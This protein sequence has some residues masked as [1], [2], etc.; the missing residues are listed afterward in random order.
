MRKVLALMA[1]FLAVA[2]LA[3]P[4]NPPPCQAPFVDMTQDVK[5][6]GSFTYTFDASYDYK[7][8][9]VGECP[10]FTG[11]ACCKDFYEEPWY[12]RS[13]FGYTLTPLAGTW[14]CTA[15]G[16]KM[17]TSRLHAT[18]E[19][20][21]VNGV[22]TLFDHVIIDIYGGQSGEKDNYFEKLEMTFDGTATGGKLA[23]TKDYGNSKLHA[24]VGASGTDIVSLTDSEEVHI[25]MT[26]PTYRYFPGIE[27]KITASG[28]GN[29]TIGAIWYWQYPDPARYFY[30]KETAAGVFEITKSIK[31]EDVTPQPEYAPTAPA[32]PSAP[33]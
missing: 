33:V 12:G 28:Q 25:Y 4:L 13:Q 16:G 2:V 22:F 6:T 31:M 26:L 7:T 21:A 29:F 20:S 5:V 30:L 32:H 27:F 8:C 1:L 19:L 9:Y 23:F 15:L 17:R 18:V 14:N 11:E 24:A 3:T 10:V